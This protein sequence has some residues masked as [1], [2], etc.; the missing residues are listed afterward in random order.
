MCTSKEYE[1]VPAAGSNG[2]WDGPG[3]REWASD[4]RTLLL[5]PDEPDPPSDNFLRPSPKVCAT[6]CLTIELVALLSG[7]DAS[8]VLRASC[9]SL[10]LPLVQS[11]CL[12]FLVPFS[13]NCRSMQ[14]LGTLKKFKLYSHWRVPDP[15]KLSA[16]AL[17][18]SYRILM[19]I[20]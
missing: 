10:P 2:S 12:R 16:S 7:D 15:P 3:A 5:D 11:P 6:V 9:L 17:P 18:D 19:Q 20:Q 8:T 13:F 1:E 4:T 14:I